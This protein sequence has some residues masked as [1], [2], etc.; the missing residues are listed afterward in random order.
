MGGCTSKSTAVVS[1]PHE[2]QLRRLMRQNS[3]KE[4]LQ[5]QLDAYHRRPQ[6][7]ARKVNKVRPAPIM[8]E[9]PASLDESKLIHAISVSNLDM[10]VSLGSA[11]HSSNSSMSGVELD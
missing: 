6:Q 8:I 5:R 9:N 1:V 2:V 3:S 7:I 10:E 11:V 4:D